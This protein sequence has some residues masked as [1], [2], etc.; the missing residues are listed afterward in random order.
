MKAPTEEHIKR[1]NKKNRPI[2]PVVID[3]IVA[4]KLRPHQIEGLDISRPIDICSASLVKVSSSCTN[5][6]WVF[7][8]TKDKAVYLQMKCKS[9]QYSCC[10]ELILSTGVWGKHCR[11]VYAF[12]SSSLTC[13]TPFLQTISLVWTLLSITILLSSVTRSYTANRT[14]SLRWCYTFG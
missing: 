1:W 9:F 7:G 8:S 14:E 10:S 12:P 4:Q 2:F 5:P 13:L 11:H 3:P 6:L